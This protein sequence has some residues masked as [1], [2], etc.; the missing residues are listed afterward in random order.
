MLA[1]LN[2]L[3]DVLAAF[4]GVVLA[5]STF[6]GLVAAKTKNKTD[7]KVAAWLKWLWQKVSFFS[8][9][10]QGPK[11]PTTTPA[12]SGEMSLP[13]SKPFEP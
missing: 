13:G 8:L 12:I 11:P 9:G 1:N 3:Q 2:W 10:N 4:G 5:A 7:D 6:I